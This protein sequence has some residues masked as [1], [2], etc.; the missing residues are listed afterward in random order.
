[1]RFK[2]AVSPLIAT[3]LLIVVAVILV[4]VVLTWGKGFVSDSVAEIDTIGSDACSKALGTLSASNCLITD[5]N[6]FSFQL[7]NLSGTYTHTG[8]FDVD[9]YQ[10]QVQGTA[11][12]V[13]TEDGLNPGQTKMVVIDTDD[14]SNFSGETGFDSP[15]YNLRITSDVCP[16][17]GFTTITCN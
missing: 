1:M 5:Q 14:V 10:G 13:L 15:P 3:I 12:S 7:R 6:T 16:A 2:K 17:D 4:T 8:N 9:V 11:T